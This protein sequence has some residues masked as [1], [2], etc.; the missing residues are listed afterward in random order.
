MQPIEMIAWFTLEGTPTIII[1]GAVL[2]EGIE[3]L[4]RQKVPPHCSLQYGGTFINIQCPP[5]VR[6]DAS[7]TLPLLEIV[8]QESSG[9]FLEWLILQDI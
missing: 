4:V 2:S 3:D 6:Q 9:H 1:L 5:S 7:S 8:G